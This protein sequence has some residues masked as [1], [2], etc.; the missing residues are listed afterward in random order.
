MIPKHHIFAVLFIFFILRNEQVQAS[1]QDRD[2]LFMMEEKTLFMSTTIQKSRGYSKPVADSVVY[3][4]WWFTAQ[5]LCSEDIFTD[6]VSIEYGERAAKRHNMESSLFIT[7]GML[8]S[9]LLKDQLRE[10][11]G[12]IPPFCEVMWDIRK[13]TEKTKN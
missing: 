11:P 4:A 2:A 7:E 3:F 9:I 6:A 10:R 13:K 5:S 8:A 1:E 12:L